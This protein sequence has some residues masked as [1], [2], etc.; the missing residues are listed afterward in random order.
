M[1]TRRDDIDFANNVRAAMELTTPRFGWSLV[2]ALLGLIFVG[3]IWAAFAEL[4]EVTR[5]D[6]RVIPS[7]LTQVVQ[8]LDAGIVSDIRVREGDVT[9]PDQVVVVLDDTAFA[10][11]LGE[12]TQKRAALLARITRLRAE[13]E[14]TEPSFAEGLRTTARSTVE[15]EAALFGARKSKLDLDLAVLDKQKL[16]RQQE[17]EE[18][19]VKETA[20]STAIELAT[21]EYDLTQRLNQQRVIPEIEFL[22]IARELEQQRGELRVVQSARPRTLAAI[23]EAVAR[24][25]NIKAVFNA[26]VRDEL[27]RLRGELSVTDEQIKAAADKVGRAEMRAPN[28]RGVVNKVSVTSIGAVIQ[29]GTNV[30]EI[31]PLDDT[32]LIEARVRPQDVAFIHPGQTATVKITAYDY[33]IYGTL[34]GTVER[35]S[36][37]TITNEKDETFYR[38]IVR[39][40]KSFLGSE[41]KPLPI[42][43]GMV[44]S[45]DILTGKKTV[46]DYILKPI[47]KAR[48]E[49]LRER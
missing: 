8:S 24:G 31:I 12:L 21:K 42:I 27:A 19:S 26:E 49:A 28:V 39:T 33:T 1:T 43:P 40:D 29:P 46:L 44:A 4:E 13:A 3:L 10:S 48:Y 15:A 2:L 37:D 32:L 34:T 41:S 22:R 25:R 20:L 35:I 47:K 18:L 17:L 6:A 7:R 9:E 14:G 16:Q 11:Q 38:V 45:V 30:V 36:A 23:D 5:G